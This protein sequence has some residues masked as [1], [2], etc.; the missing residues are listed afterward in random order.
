MEI[1]KVG[2]NTKN[3]EGIK[4]SREIRKTF[5][6]YL[7]AKQGAKKENDTIDYNNVSVEQ[8]YTSWLATFADSEDFKATMAEEQKAKVNA[9]NKRD[10]K[11]LKKLND[12]KALYIEAGY[13]DEEAQKLAEIAVSQEKKG[14]KKAAE[15]TTE[16]K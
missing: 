7:K 15:K 5:E 11:L 9:K 14:R 1:V 10:E 13:S 8:L 4:I 16:Q 3:A 2:T 12:K 6:A